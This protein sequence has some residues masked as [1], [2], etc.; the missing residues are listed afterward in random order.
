MLP[1]SPSLQPPSFPIASP[2]S[3]ASVG[4]VIP[5]VVYYLKILALLYCSSLSVISPSVLS[6]L[7]AVPQGSFGVTVTPNFPHMVSE[8]T[9]KV[10]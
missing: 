8:L 9:G 6:S 10:F 2:K 7:H 4:D 5:D 3:P 1:L